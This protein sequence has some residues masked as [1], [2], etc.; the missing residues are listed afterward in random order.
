MST[1]CWLNGML[2]PIATTRIDPMDR[3]FVLGDGVFETIAIRHGQPAHLCLHLLRMR[4]GAMRLGIRYEW[5][6][7][8]I[9]E[10]IASLVAS[11][12]SGLLAARL[13]LSRGASARGVLPDRDSTSTLLITVAPVDEPPSR[14]EAIISRITCRNEKSPLASLKTT[15]Y[16][17]NILARQDA[18]QSGAN[19][20]VLLN[21]VGR[22]AEASA[23]NILLWLSGRLFTPPVA[24]GA[25][26]GIARAVL[27]Q[28]CDINER[29]LTEKELLTADALFLT[30]SL[31]VREVDRLEQRD[32][33]PAP[34]QLA[35]LR[36]ALEGSRPER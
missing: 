8:Q 10:A 23:A 11:S 35:R 25:L 36:A 31:G 26:P 13:T 18:Q 21:T 2:G 16:L 15:N 30:N 20:A 3:G 22:V 34:E 1:T 6:D 19:E 24:D 17:D 27:M 5:D 4:A 28:A 14:V 7:I 12:K 9:G 32:Y 33:Q 29:S